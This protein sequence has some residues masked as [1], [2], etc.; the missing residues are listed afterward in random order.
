MPNRSNAKEPVRTLAKEFRLPISVAR[1]RLVVREWLQR[2]VPWG[3]AGAILAAVIAWAPKAISIPDWNPNWSLWAIPLGAILG[4]A[5]AAIDA[6][7]RAPSALQTALEID[8]RFG[9]RERLSSLLQLRPQEADSPV[10]KLLESDT[11]NRVERIDVRDQFPIEFPRALAVPALLLAVAGSSWLA[12]NRSSPNLSAAITSPSATVEKVR[13]STRPLIEQLKKKQQEAIE[14]GDPAAAEIFKN[15]EKQLEQLRTASGIDEKKALAT[16]NELNQQLQDR[17]S[18]LGS[19]QQ[20]RQ[21]LKEQMAAVQDGPAEKLAKAL[22]EGDMTAAS[23]E[24]QKLMDQ[25]KNGDLDEASR[26]KMAEQMKKMAEA[27]KAASERQKEAM[28]QLQ[29]RLEQAEQTGDVQKAA[30]LR[31]QLEKMEQQAAAEQGKKES[32]E[33]SQQRQQEMKELQKQITEA[34]Q[35]GDQQKAEQ[36]QEELDSMMEQQQMSQS[37]SQKMQSAMQE[38]QEALEKGD[39]QATEKS[40]KELQEQVEQMESEMESLEEL[41]SLMDQVAQ[42]KGEMKGSQRGNRPGEGSGEGEGEGDR[43]EEESQTDT[44]ESQVRDRFRK[45]ESFQGGKIRGVNRKGVTKEEVKQAILAEQPEEAKSLESAVLP[46]A[47][48]DQ[49]REYFDRMR[50]GDRESDQ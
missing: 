32:P 33:E 36:L 29:K 26:Q 48:R 46:K 19:G 3:T 4:A 23:E 8:R 38:L 24:L 50:Q 5:I 45:G 39:M 11:R 1:R 41:D 28:Q 27:L 21:Q 30:Q 34:M 25:M 14:K 42:S 6:W 13:Q 10:G 18:E 40:L 15:M 47:Q 17:K 31:K 35:G 49:T 12:T 20:L 44:F 7:W 9:L 2:L 37:Q 22:Q 43:D 16:L